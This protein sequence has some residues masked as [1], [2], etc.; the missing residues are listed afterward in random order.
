MSRAAPGP[1]APGVSPNSK[2]PLF[3]PA[4]LRRR[5]RDCLRLYDRYW[6]GDRKRKVR[7]LQKGKLLPEGQQRRGQ[8]ISPFRA[9][10][11]LRRLC[12]GHPLVLA[13]SRPLELK[14]G[15]LSGSV[16]DSYSCQGMAAGCLGGTSVASPSLACIV[17]LAGSE[18]PVPRPNFLSFTPA[19]ELMLS[20]TPS[21]SAGSYNARPGWDFVTGVG[22][23]QGT[24]GKWALLG[25]RLDVTCISAPPRCVFPP[26]HL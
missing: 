9:I 26:A 6:P 21:G 14:W 23:N 16:Y 11:L 4:L 3:A 19:S 22:S 24:F 25:G 13:E 2:S 1:A 8:M 10:G 5:H 12:A 15:E 17:N 18:T 7:D 20:G